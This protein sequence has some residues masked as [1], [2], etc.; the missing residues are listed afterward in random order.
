MGQRELR[1]A[2]QRVYGA[3]TQVRLCL[4]AI[5]PSLPMARTL[6]PFLA[7][8]IVSVL[9]SHTC[10]ELP[11][12]ICPARH[13]QSFN[14]TWLRRKLAEGRWGQGPAAQPILHAACRCDR[15]QV[16][17]PRGLASLLCLESQFGTAN[18]VRSSLLLDCSPGRQGR[19]R[20]QGPQAP[21]WQGP[22]PPHAH[23]P[24][25]ALRGCCS[26]SR[27][28]GCRGGGGSRGTEALELAR[29][30][31]ATAAPVLALPTAWVCLS[32]CLSVCQSSLCCACLPQVDQR[33]Q[34]L[35]PNYRVPGPQG[36]RGRRAAGARRA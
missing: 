17:R 4:A 18:P 19:R 32:V 3:V 26:G 35:L 13:P 27:A 23:R 36:G 11:A 30:A 6:I 25:R 9:E 33:A 8:P 10:H 14:N 21:R 24:G 12:L 20:W 7:G 29:V 15:V 5:K 22:A 34:A 2:F 28:A 1:E 31:P 16:A